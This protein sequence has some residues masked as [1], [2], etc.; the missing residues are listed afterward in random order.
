MLQTKTHHVLDYA[1][2]HSLLEY[3]KINILGL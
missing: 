2:I 3:K 1:K